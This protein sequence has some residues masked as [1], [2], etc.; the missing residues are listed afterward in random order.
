MPSLDIFN[1]DAFGLVSMTEAINDTPHQ[2]GRLGQLGLFAEDG[3][4]TTALQI[5]QQGTT[6]SLV[7]AGQR[8][9]SGRVETSDK[10]KV[11][12]INTVHLPQRATIGADEVQNVRAFGSDS[13]L[14]TVQN[15]VNKRL[16][17]MR[18]NLDTT[19]EYQRIGAIKGQVLDSDGSTVLLDLF[20]TFGVSQTTH[21]M[22]LGSDTTKVKVKVVEAARKMEAALGG[23]QYTG[24][25]VLCSASFFDAFVGQKTVLEAYDRWMDG[26][27]LRDDN[28]NGF[29]FAGAYWEE[30]RG[31][32]G[33]VNF[34]ADDTAYMIP[35]GVPDLF[36]TNYAPADYMETAN[37][38]GL[39][40]YAK[41]ELE[42]FGKGVEIESQSN[43]ISI[44]T[45][46]A[47]PVKLTIA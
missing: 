4:T 2:P 11:I 30:Y 39:P 22:L 42:R 9:Q 45:R 31:K 20:N 27:F 29:Y 23:L 14:E 8:G 32:I 16:A 40:Y 18:R 15:V 33:S 12:P 44:C 21:A 1:D 3:I 46:P 41:Q 28:R 38:L 24:K 6:I 37:T 35:E 43:P 25:R 36:V 17:K 7:P 26:Q 19:I 47:V 34:I 10:R 13:E 5:E